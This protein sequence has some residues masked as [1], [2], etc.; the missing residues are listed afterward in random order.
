MRP[1]LDPLQTAPDAFEAMRSF[2]G[3]FLRCGLEPWLLELV[4]IR[5][6][7]MSGCASCLDVNAREAPPRQETERVGARHR[8]TRTASAARLI[9]NGLQKG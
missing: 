1:R 8:F 5:A 9:R 3:Y 6:S 2:S 4:Q 7:Q